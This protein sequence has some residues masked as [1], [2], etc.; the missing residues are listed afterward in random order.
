VIPDERVAPERSALL[1]GR[2]PALDRAVRWASSAPRPGAG[3][4]SRVT[5]Y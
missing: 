5:P 4:N 2:D 3:T 1:Q